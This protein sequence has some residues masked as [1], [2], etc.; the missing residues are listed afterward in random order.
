MAKDSGKNLKALVAADRR[1]RR[2]A[3]DVVLRERLIAYTERRRLEGATTREVAEELGMSV[4]T[5]SY[6]RSR[7]AEPA[8]QRV[9]IVSE[10]PAAAEEPR[11][12]LL[13][14]CGTMLENVTLGEVAELWRK[15]S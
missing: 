11:F 6:W 14:P 8:L 5:V 9:Q 10:H 15:L 7:R 4:A 13:G 3:F 12:R 1:D 2:G